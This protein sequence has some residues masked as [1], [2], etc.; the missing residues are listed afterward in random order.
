MLNLIL[1]A[2]G[3]LPLIFGDARD[4]LVGSRATAQCA[5]R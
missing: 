1:A 3:A 2:F 4:A 5:E